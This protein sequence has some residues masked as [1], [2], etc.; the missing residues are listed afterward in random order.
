MKTFAFKWRCRRTTSRKL[1]VFGLHVL[2]ENPKILDDYFQIWLT[3]EHVAK[4][5]CV[6]C[7]DHQGRHLKKR[8]KERPA[9]CNN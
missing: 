1:A 8:K 4:F 9:K 3:S 7:D 5:G 6:L 2:G